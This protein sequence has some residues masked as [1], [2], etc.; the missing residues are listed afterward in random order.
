MLNL[1]TLAD[2]GDITGKVVI[3]RADL[4]VPIANGEVTSDYR[5]RKIAPTI[6]YLMQ[7]QA[8]VVVLGHLGRPEGKYVDELSLM[9]VRFELGKQLGSHVK[10]AHIPNSRNSIIFMENGEVLMLENVRFHPEEETTDAKARA[11]FVDGL[12]QLGQAYVNDAFST[13]RLHASN[14][15][16]AKKFENR[17]AGMQVI[18][19]VEHLTQLRDNV[20]KPYVAVIGGAKL[21]TKIDVLKSLVQKAD[22]ILL[23]GAMAYTFLA[24][25]GTEVGDSAVEKDKIKVAEEIIKLAKKHKCELML[26]VDHIC[27]AEF[28]ESTKPI[29]VETQHIPKGMMGLD[30]GE[31]TLAGYL[32]IIKSAKTVMWNGP[33]GVFEWDNFSRGTEAVGEYIGLSAPVDTYKVAGGGDTIAAMDKLKINM[34]NFDHVSVGGGAMLAFLAGE[35]FPILEI[36]KK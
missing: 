16:L 3:V 14:Y 4:D 25:Q 24:A 13:Y 1:R 30:I 11:A 35:K 7:K 33:M 31:R 21:D 18:S 22:Y 2:L 20:E 27:G 17:A 8:K 9:P 28:S 12:A 34:K 36:L 23:G 26:P 6:K 5:I 15:D 29:E 10:F 19:E 32:E